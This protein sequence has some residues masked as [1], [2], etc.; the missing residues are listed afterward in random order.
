MSLALAGLAVVEAASGQI[1]RPVGPAPPAAQTLPQIPP[2]QNTRAGISFVG[3]QMCANCHNGIAGT[4]RSTAMGESITRP[5]DPRQLAFAADGAK[6]FDPQL[7]RYFEVRREGDSIVQSEFALQGAK[8]ALFQHTEKIAFAVGGGINGYSYLVWRG[9]YLFQAPLSYYSRRQAWDLSPGHELG[10]NRPILADCIACHSGRARPIAG[11]DGLYHRPA[12]KEL[13]IGCENCHGPGQLHV[14]QRMAGNPV[15]LERD[16]TIVNPAKLPGWLADNICMSCHQSGEAVVFQPGKNH[17]DFRPGLPLGLTEAIFKLPPGRIDAPESPL[18]DHYSLMIASECYIKSNGGLHCITCHDP[19]VQP[20]PQQA[21][22]YFR[23]KCLGCH[24][25]QSCSVGLSKRLKQKPADNCVGCHMP[26]QPLKTISHSALTAHRIVRR[27][28]RPYPGAALRTANSRLPGVWELTAA[29][30]PGLTPLPLRTRL[31][32]YQALMQA[33]PQ[34]FRQPFQQALEQAATELPNDPTILGILARQAMHQGEAGREKSTA[35]LWRAIEAGST[36]PPDY[37]LL[38]E[39]L[40]RAGNAAQAAQVLEH[41]IALAPYTPSL[42][43]VLA[44]CYQVLGEQKKALEAAQQGTK[45][46]PENQPL[47]RL[48]QQLSAAVPKPAA[49]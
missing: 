49:P 4:F 35:L 47:R 43:G 26:R 46:F 14:Q 18:L 2:Y 22:T 33:R 23:A 15:S 39:N 45:L 38:G 30:V 16:L 34:Q 13:S 25:E 10:F 9:N 28:D 6:L 12:F 32:A 36:W 29:P 5:S 19:H 1:S 40:L 21:A 31:L 7:G 27:P 20:G 48:E 17:L 8:K 11:R 42:Y 3:S 44:I 24:S 41:G 37:Q